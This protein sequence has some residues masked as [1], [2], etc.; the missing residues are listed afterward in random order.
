MYLPGRPLVRVLFKASGEGDVCSR[1]TG[2]D[3]TRNSTDDPSLILA[4]IIALGRI[5]VRMRPRDQGVQ[6]HCLGQLLINHVTLDRPVTYQT[7]S[8]H[9]YKRE[10]LIGLLWGLQE[11]PYKVLNTSLGLGGWFYCLT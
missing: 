11:F 5:M 6:G 10:M 1:M 7:L 2:T 8:L 9:F 3:I 4:E